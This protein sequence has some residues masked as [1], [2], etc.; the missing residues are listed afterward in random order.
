[1]AIVPLCNVPPGANVICSDVIY[2]LQVRDE[3]DLSLKVR[4]APHGN[5]DSLKHKLRSDC[6]MC[7]PVGMLILIS[8]AALHGWRL[9]KLY[10]KSA[11][12]QTGNAE[13]D[14]Y[15]VPPRESSDHGRAQWLLLTPA[16]GLVITNVKW[17]AK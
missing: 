5:E 13:R 16:Y 8:T 4:I 10:V 14:V 11:F 1:M 3:N 7:I 6:A 9:H 15:V 12:L 2:K 17:H